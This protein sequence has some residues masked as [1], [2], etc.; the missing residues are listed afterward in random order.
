M[1]GSSR[2]ENRRARANCYKTSLLE[3]SRRRGWGGRP[4]VK[5]GQRFP[6]GA[7]QDSTWFQSR[8]D[9]RLLATPPPNQSQTHPDVCIT[10][11]L[12]Q[13]PASSHC[14]PC[15]AP[16]GHTWNALQPL[17][18][19]K[20]GR[21]CSKH[22]HRGAVYRAVYSSHS[23]IHEVM[24]QHRPWAAPGLLLLGGRFRV[25]HRK[26]HGGPVCTQWGDVFPDGTPSRKWSKNP[27]Q[28]RKGLEASASSTARGNPPGLRDRALSSQRQGATAAPSLPSL[29]AETLLCVSG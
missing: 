4:T 11:C 3:G 2:G 24:K 8:K 13:V 7:K 1:T 9:S 26:W 10:S 27:S 16:A 18:L 17:L 21:N 20:A 25:L 22:S 19:S 29:R 15:L 28:S 23:V 14:W 12:P 6:R 5:L